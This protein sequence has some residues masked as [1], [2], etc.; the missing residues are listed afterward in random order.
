MTSTNGPAPTRRRV[1][2]G[3]AAVLLGVALFAAG[4][5]G[6]DP[7]GATEQSSRARADTAPREAA[8]AD[9]LGTRISLLQRRL[10]DVPGDATGWATLGLDYVQQAKDTA[11][12]S[13]YA[14]AEE[15]LRRSLE[16]EATENFTAMAGHA[17]LAAAR[18][19]FTTSLDWARKAQVINPY[20]ATL[21]GTL[22]DALTQLGRYQESFE[23]VQR[24]VDLRPGTPSLA[25][26]SYAWE[27]RGEIDTA[28]EHMQRALEMA[29]SPA[30]RAFTRRYLCELALTAGDSPGALAHADAGLRAEPGNSDL[31][32]ARA[33]VELALGRTGDALAD[34]TAAVARVPRPEYVLELGE[35]YQSLGDTAKAQEQYDVFRAQQRLFADNGVA[36]D[37]DATLFE[38]DH[39]DPAKALELGRAGVRVRPFLDMKDAYAWALHV[40]GRDREALEYSRAATELGT[41]N[42]LHH[43]H[44]GAIELA[45]GHHD[46][47]REEF[48]RALAVNPAFHPLH[49]PAA[50]AALTSLG[51]H[52]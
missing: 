46:R 43:Y 30:D 40:N 36:A 23:A 24:M 37:A 32:R 34:Y 48:K 51:E 6:L 47:A 7:R 39:G 50:K 22:A 1:R 42:A 31:L 44:Q 45:L 28:R 15:V 14:K 11:D 12:P 3:I 13:Y 35:L 16:S 52:A 20:N 17:A 33:R 21:Y 27:L 49:A 19:D 25:R 9:A 10:R 26:A 41:H 38:A 8:R 2:S 29:G 5:V 4:A 18:H